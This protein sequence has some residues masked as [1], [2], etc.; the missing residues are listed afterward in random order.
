MPRKSS[1]PNKSEY[2]KVREKLNLTREEASD[3]LGFITSDRLEKIEN[4]R[5]PI[6]P[7]EVLAMAEKYK[8]PEL[9]N[10]YCSRECPIGQK[11]VPQI[12]VTSLSQI[13]LE[14]IAALNSMNKKKDRL[15]EITV[16]G[17]ISE[18]EYKDFKEI[19]EELAK[20][21]MVADTLQLWCDQMIMDGVIDESKL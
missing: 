15:I 1:N 18:D 2:L 11:Y 8:T 3:L 10:Y 7:I 6:Q 21:S 14:M 12:K 9:C 13:T 19:R 4:G 5:S 20:I 16:D 17:E